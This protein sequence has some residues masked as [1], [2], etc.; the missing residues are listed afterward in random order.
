MIIKLGIWAF[1]IFRIVLMAT[2][3]GPAYTQATLRLTPETDRPYL[4]N[5]TGFAFAFGLSK[6]LDPSIGFFNVTYNTY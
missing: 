6:P 5:E 4:P 1:F 3:F 2:R